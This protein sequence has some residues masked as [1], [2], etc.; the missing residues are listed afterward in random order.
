MSVFSF[1]EL[2]DEQLQDLLRNKLSKNSK[3]V[4]AHAVTILTAYGGDRNLSLVAIDALKPNELNRLLSKFYAEVRKVHGSFYLKN[5]LL[6]IRYGL[7]KHF[8]ANG[9]DISNDPCFLHSSNMFSY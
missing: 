3:A 8:L 9:A 6:A 1:A 7:E 4:I 2:L 5:D